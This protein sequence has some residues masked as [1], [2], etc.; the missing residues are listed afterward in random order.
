MTAVDVLDEL[1]A[2]GITATASGEKLLLVPGS[3][4]PQDLLAKVKTHKNE[5]LELVN[6][7]PEGSEVVS[8]TAC[9]CD[10]LP[11]Q[12][13]NGHMALAGC[14]PDYQ[15]C[16]K[17]GYTWR[18]QICEGCRRCRGDNSLLGRQYPSE[19]GV[20]GDGQP[21]LLDRPPSTAV[22]LQRL[23]DHL[24]DPVVFATWLE[25]AMGCTDPK[26]EK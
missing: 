5:L 13:E 12:V 21:P 11:S 9:S 25:W 24:A 23:L 17:C 14:G 15:K 1:A 6:Q 22:E 16:V 4:V 8:S 7:P 2:L 20:P 18:C 10:P 26:E 3:K 19:K